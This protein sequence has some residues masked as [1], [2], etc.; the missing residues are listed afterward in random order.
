MSERHR[1]RGGGHD[2]PL[3]SALAGITARIVVIIIGGFPRD[4]QPRCS[5]WPREC[6]RTNIERTKATARDQIVLSQK[7]DGRCGEG[8]EKRETHETQQDTFECTY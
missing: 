2:A 1:W 8:E 4:V 7:S 3:L 5:D 6:A